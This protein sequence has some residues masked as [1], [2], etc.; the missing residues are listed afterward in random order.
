[1]NISVDKIPPSQKEIK[2]NLGP[3]CPVPRAG[4]SRQAA[5]HACPILV[6][7]GKNSIITLE[8]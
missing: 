7:T 1:M 5:D 2:P 4:S 8:V 3:S 6:M